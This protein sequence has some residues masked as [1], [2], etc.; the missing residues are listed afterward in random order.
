M[1]A[2]LAKRARRDNYCV[3]LSSLSRVKRGT[4]CNPVLPRMNQQ[5]SGTGNCWGSN[6]LS[7]M[8]YIAVEFGKSVDYSILHQGIHHSF[9]C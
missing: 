1:H 2:A 9:Y 6:P 8:L 4:V 7:T 5:P 3:C